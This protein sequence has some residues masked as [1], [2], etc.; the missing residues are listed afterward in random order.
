MAA[1]GLHCC[2]R[3]FSQCRVQGLPS[4]CSGSSLWWDLVVCRPCST[5]LVVVV[6]GVSCPKACGIFP[7]QLSNLCPPH[8][9]VE[10][11]PLYHQGRP[12]MCIL[13]KNLW[14]I[15]RSWKYSH[16]T[17]I[18]KFVYHLLFLGLELWINKFLFDMT[19]SL[20]LISLSS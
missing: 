10:S 1:L 14:P 20:R 4:C 19:Y 3:A 5:G 16:V 13:N 15:S 7:D 2:V 11:Y 18:R 17:P 9:Q 6:H 12:C 8:W